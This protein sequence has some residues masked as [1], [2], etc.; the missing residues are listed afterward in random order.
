MENV[1]RTAMMHNQGC[2]KCGAF[3]PS[4]ELL[5]P[6]CGNTNGAPLSEPK[7]FALKKNGCAIWTPSVPKAD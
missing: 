2:D 3:V 6:R 4:T 1:D 5:G 7:M